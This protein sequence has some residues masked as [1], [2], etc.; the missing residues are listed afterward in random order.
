MSILNFLYTDE[1]VIAMAD[2]LAS[3]AG[4]IP[5][6]F[7]TKIFALPHINTIICGTGNYNTV[8]AWCN[9]IQTSV[10]ANNVDD[11]DQISPENIRNIY[12]KITGDNLIS[13]TIYHFGFIEKEGKYLGY[14]YR[15]KNNF[16]SE[17]LEKGFG[18]KP[19]D[20]I[21]IE[22][23]LSVYDGDRNKVFVEICK[24]QKEVDD[25]RS[26]D[27]R[28]GIGGSV[29]LYKMQGKNITINH[30]MDYPNKD[31]DNLAI[32]NKAIYG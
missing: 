23:I 27:E 4:G 8:L 7:V 3:T 22:K 17:K 19:P 31:E 28:L 9:F 16:V 29:Y 21:D 18:I 26:K 24:K 2:T 14:A 20:E 10:I 1:Y 13:T 11:L 12:N 15:S 5:H 32:R 30:L 6:M 25:N